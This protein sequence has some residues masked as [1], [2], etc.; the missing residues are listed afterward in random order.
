M[1]AIEAEP[2]AAVLREFGV[3]PLARPVPQTGGFSGAGVWKVASDAGDFCLRRWPR[4]T[5]PRER[6]RGLHRLLA[7][8]KD[9]GLDT[10]AVPLPSNRGE[11]LASIGGDGWQLEPWLPGRADFQSRPTS[12]RLAAAMRALAQWHLAARLFQPRPQEAEW[13]A[14]VEYGRPLGIATRSELIRDW[15]DGRT[16]RLRLA[17]SHDTSDAL[18]PIAEPMLMLFERAVPIVAAELSAATQRVPLHPCL[19]DVWH[20]HV[21]FIDNRVSGLIDP[22]ACRVDSVSADLSRL[23]GSLLG[24]ETRRWEEALDAYATVRPLSFEERQLV[25]ILDRSGVL[26]SGMT[27]L[28]RHYVQRAP[29]ASIAAVVPRL[30]A[31]LERLE[32]LVRRV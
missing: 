15:L 4:G 6:L 18:R 11:T 10:V 8:L 27:W 7:H 21:L 26:L 30:I 17:I 22:S 23:L 25:R 28:D 31:N 32:S 1:P 2:L 24:D 9:C 5:G 14:P 20:D 16:A 3:T 19:R 13:F 12:A 29:I